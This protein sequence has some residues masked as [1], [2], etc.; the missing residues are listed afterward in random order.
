VGLTLW[1]Y[2]KPNQFIATPTE[3]PAQ[4]VNYQ[5]VEL[6]VPVLEYTPPRAFAT[7][8]ALATEIQLGF[9]VEFPNYA[10]I[11]YQSN[12]PYG[13]LG[14]SWYVYLRVRL[15]ARKYFGGSSD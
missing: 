1:G 12:A 4:L 6:D 2:G 7:T 5:S 14:T 13:N 3:G 9:M 10:V 11:Q 15:D 8:L